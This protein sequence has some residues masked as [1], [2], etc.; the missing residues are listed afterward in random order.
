MG[1]ELGYAVMGQAH[2]PVTGHVFM[3][4][5]TKI[6]AQHTPNIPHILTLHGGSGKKHCMVFILLFLEKYSTPTYMS[7]IERLSLRVLGL[8][9]SPQTCRYRRERR[10][11]LK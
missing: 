11:P 10:L 3:F 2:K 1:L 8:P 6:T 5:T 7:T 9:K 4:N